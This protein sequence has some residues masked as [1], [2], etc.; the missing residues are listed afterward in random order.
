MSLS[1]VLRLAWCR[2]RR[3]SLLVAFTTLTAVVVPTS[4]VVVVELTVSATLT[5]VVSVVVLAVSLVVASLATLEV[6]SV[7]LVAT[8]TTILTT[9]LATELE[10]FHEVLLHFLEAAL[11]TL[12]ME[13]LSGHPELDAQGTSTEGGRLIEALNGLLRAVD[14]FIENEVLTVRGI[15]VEVFALT[16]LN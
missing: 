16:Q 7:L 6:A 15:W 8:L 12:L 3:L 1:W 14:V 11:L 4:V 13:L 10:V 9:W 5:R 2:C